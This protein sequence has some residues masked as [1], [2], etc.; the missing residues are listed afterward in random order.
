MPDEPNKQMDETLRA[1]AQERRKAPEV[2]LHPA[3]RNLLQAEVKRAFGSR[4]AF[5]WWRNLRAF[6]PHLAF[7]GAEE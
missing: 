7:G 6:W 3:T 4:S 2:S 5:P 1:Y